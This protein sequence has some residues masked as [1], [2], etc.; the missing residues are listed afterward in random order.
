MKKIL[1]LFT[2][3]ALA[4]NT[5]AS[6][7]SV[8]IN[9]QMQDIQ[10]GTVIQLIPGATHKDEKPV[11][12]T[13]VSNGQ[14]SFTIEIDGARYFNVY[15]P[16]RQKQRN[17][18][19]QIMVAPGD[20]VTVTG[21]F[22]QYKVEGSEIYEQYL[23]KFENPRAVLDNIYAEK[24]QKFADVYTKMGNAR[25][26]HDQDQIKLISESEEYQ[27]AQKADSDF[28]NLVNDSI[29]R[30]IEK[31]ADSWWGPFIMLANTSFLP[32]EME[33]IYYKFSDEAKNSY[34]GKLVAD[35]L[36]GVLGAAPEFKAK[37]KEGNEHSLAQILEANDYVLIDFWASWCNPCRKLVPQLKELAQ[38]YA[39]KGMAVVSISI[40][41]DQ[42]AWL[43]AVAE[44]EM[45]WL[46]LIDEDGISGAYG[47]SGVPSM[48]LID[49]KGN[50]LF[51]KQGGAGVVT[52]LKEQFGE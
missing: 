16:A 40:D 8:V 27:A 6:D 41:K 9:F 33:T 5:N 38:K 1:L 22:D 18:R 43:K 21:S 7:K 24:E 45:T 19:I 35:E 36:F 11:A 39:S 52:K 2:A 26:T 44:E 20:N 51:S 10:D 29:N 30:D 42:A 49:K 32:S 47:V 12:E 48:Y 25:K 28:F 31:N 4:I 15:I 23:E 50:V 13:T 37:D 14:F 3:I 17:N 46:N 34:Y